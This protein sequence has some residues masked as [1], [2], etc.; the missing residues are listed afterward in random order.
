MSPIAVVIVNFKTPEHLRA[1]LASVMAEAPGEVVV[2]DN[3][4]SD[5]SVEMV[6]DSFPDVVVHG[7][8]SNIGY[9]TAANQAMASCACEYVLLLNA[10]TRLTP[11]ALA[12]LADYLDAHPLA[13]I[14]GPRLVGEDG[15][16]QASCYP[17]PTALNTL[18]E[19]S[20]IAVL[21]GR[22]IRRSLPS[23]GKFYL[24]T[25]AHDDSRVVPWVKGAALA[26]RRKAFD[27]VAGFD[28]SFFLYFEDADLCRR[29]Q[30]M[31]W[32]IHFSPAAIVVHIGGASSSQ[33]AAETSLRL[34][35][36]TLQY[37]K[38]HSSP[39]QFAMAA[40]IIRGIVL[41]SRLVS[42]VRLWWTRDPR[43]RKEISRHLLSNRQLLRR[44][45]NASPNGAG[46]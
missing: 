37:Y 12:A 16:L 28:E 32:E 43:K 17:F 45:S 10:D 1:C 24:R 25:W 44:G 30:T 13:A 36:S 22:R 46:A 41:A 35:A 23:L 27:S 29:L 14:V 6:R 2:V 31:G 8:E 42:T 40:I 9:G 18:L 4:S 34:L 3:A 39:M 20:K 38:C 15:A 11:G 19:N 33:F 21:L 5:G 26:I 7:N